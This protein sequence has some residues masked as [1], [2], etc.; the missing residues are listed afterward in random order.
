MTLYRRLE[1]AARDV[2]GPVN[3]RLAGS[4]SR[5]VEGRACYQ[6]AMDDAVNALGIRAISELHER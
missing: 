6:E 4:V 1:S 5:A 2:C 3:I